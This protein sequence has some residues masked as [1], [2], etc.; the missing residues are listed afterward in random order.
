MSGVK[1]DNTPQ[2]QNSCFVS[3]PSIE[4]GAKNLSFYF[5]ALQLS[6]DVHNDKPASL[7]KQEAENHQ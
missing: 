5:L 1:V 4:L 2:P 6:V 7:T 3:K